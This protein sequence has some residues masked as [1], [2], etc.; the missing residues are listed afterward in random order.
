MRKLPIKVPA[1]TC[2]MPPTGGSETLFA[3]FSGQVIAQTI[4]FALAIVVLR[5]RPTGI[6]RAR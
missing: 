4:V 5:F 1:S 2:P 3:L 6:L